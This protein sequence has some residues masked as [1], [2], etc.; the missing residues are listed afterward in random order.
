MFFKGYGVLMKQ[1][2]LFSLLIISLA[3]NAQDS[4]KVFFFQ[5]VAWTIRLPPNFAV[6]G[7]KKALENNQKGINM[8][9]GASGVK[10]DTTG[11]KILVAA[12][13]G[14]GNFFQAA[15]VPMRVSSNAYWKRSL[16]GVKDIS[17]TT[18]IK[19][20]PSGKIDSVSSEQ[21]LDG[22]LFDK[23]RLTITIGQN[24]I[25]NFVLL[26]KYYKGYDF[27]ITYVSTQEDIKEEIENALKSSR[28]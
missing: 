4:S 28:F 21:T 9:E 17:Y 27:E 7:S 15:I 19:K 13:K 26:A 14:A 3:S 23:F 6:L 20:I 2:T 24:I 5:E 16:Q 11:V 25:L 8:M 22:L 10:V 18:F 12:T 1:L